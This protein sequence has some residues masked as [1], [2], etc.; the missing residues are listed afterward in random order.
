MQQQKQNTFNLLSAKYDLSKK[1]GHAGQEQEKSEMPKQCVAWKSLTKTCVKHV[2]HAALA[3]IPNESLQQH[4][5]VASRLQVSRWQ[6]GDLTICC[7]VVNN[8]A[9]QVISLSDEQSC[10]AGFLLKPEHIVFP[11]LLQENTARQ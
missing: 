10:A 2:M 1:H 6:N 5:F 11:I 4:P 7:L 3:P 9:E 8:T